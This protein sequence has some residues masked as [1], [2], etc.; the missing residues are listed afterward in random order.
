[1]RMQNILTSIISHDQTAYVKGRYIG[2]SIMLISNILEYTE[3]NS[4]GGIL[5]SADFEK[6]FD[7]IEHKFIF[8][9]LQSFGF[10]TQ[11]IYWVRTIFQNAGELCDEQWQLHRVHS[12]RKKQ[13][14]PLSAYHFILCLET[15]FIQIRENDNIKGIGIGDMQMMRTS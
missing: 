10:G 7:S 8:A 6:A 12:V 9:T 11:F 1:M 5:F 15:L 3:D 2:E 14:D 13:G 4:M